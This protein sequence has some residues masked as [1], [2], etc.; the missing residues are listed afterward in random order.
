MEM[1]SLQPDVLTNGQSL[2]KASEATEHAKIIAILKMTLVDADERT[3]KNV[4]Y[5]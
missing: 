5:S 3:L 4:P 1:Y 2:R